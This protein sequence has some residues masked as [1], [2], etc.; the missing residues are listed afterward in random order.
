MVGDA[1]RFREEAVCPCYYGNS[2]EKLGLRVGDMTTIV[3]TVVVTVVVLFPCSK[4]CAISIDAAA[5]NATLE[6]L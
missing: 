3:P 1:I 5:T 2:L 4:Q 6:K